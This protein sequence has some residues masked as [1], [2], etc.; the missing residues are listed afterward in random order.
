MRLVGDE[1]PVKKFCPNQVVINKIFLKELDL[2]KVMLS[3]KPR[4]NV[5]HKSVWVSW[6]ATW[7]QL[8]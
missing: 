8:S 1:F 6:I 3:R 5:N 7:V 2:S 4:V